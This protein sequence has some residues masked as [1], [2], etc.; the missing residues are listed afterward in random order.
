MSNIVTWNDYEETVEVEV[1]NDVVQWRVVCKVKEVACIHLA[2]GD[3][4]FEIRH[5]VECCSKA[6]GFWYEPGGLVHSERE[7]GDKV[8]VFIQREWDE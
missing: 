1:P 4:T 8:C 2:R 3:G 6:N 7:G 5:L